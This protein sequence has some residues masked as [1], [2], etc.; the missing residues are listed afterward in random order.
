MNGVFALG[1][2]TAKMENEMSDQ[3][4][5]IKHGTDL[6]VKS[7]DGSTYEETGQITITTSSTYYN[8]AILGEKWIELYFTIE[9]DLKAEDEEY[10][11]EELAKYD[12]ISKAVFYQI[13]AQGRKIW[14]F[15]NLDHMMNI[16]GHY[17]EFDMTDYNDVKRIYHIYWSRV[18]GYDNMFEDVKHLQWRCNEDRGLKRDHDRNKE[19][20]EEYKILATR[21]LDDM[22]SD[23]STEKE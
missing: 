16:K 11:M 19:K 5:Y 14:K 4:R 22:S 23:S 12:S 2:L 21:L 10:M 9:Y 7:I 8:S 18:R 1:M 6:K 3:D 17:R 13:K 15:F 20:Y